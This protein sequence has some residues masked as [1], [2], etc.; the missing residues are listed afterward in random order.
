MF[1]PEQMGV[2][3]HWPFC[4]SRCPYCDF[5]TYVREQ[6]F[7]QEVWLKAYI[8]VLDYYAKILPAKQV[9]S[10]FFGGGT[11]S[12]MS[13]EAVGRLINH[14]RGCWD[15]VDDVEVTLEANPTS[16]ENAK[17][18]GFAEAGVNRLSLGVQSLTDDGLKFLGR[19]HSVK[20]AMEALELAQQ[21]FSRYNLDLIYAR[22]G[23]GLQDWEVELKEAISLGAPHMSL[24][25]LTIAEKTPFYKRLRS[26]EF[27]VPEDVEGAAFYH[28]TQDMME[29][30]GLPAYEVSNHAR[31]GEECRHNLVYWHMADYIGIGA[32]AHGRY[33]LGEKKYATHDEKKPERWL[34]LVDV[35]RHGAKQE[36][37][38]TKEQLYEELLMGMR[39]YE[40]MSV[41]RVRDILDFSK[42]D[43]AVKE[44]WLV[45][46]DERLRATREGMLRLDTL[47][48]YILK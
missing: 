27:S 23:Q 20:E 34:E 37:L 36:V 33:R 9:A 11:P 39:L 12:L 46:E 7:D 44:R 18:R 13:P 14:V 2:Y 5:N 17:L 4:K 48:S 41:F 16:V 35:H 30:G 42:I 1:R 3:I 43:I 19:E 32:G 45:H 24:Y 6:N 21:Y 10:I 15:V 8:R 26:G 47:L 25:Q 31:E 38:S 40:G 22:P 28:L 29:A